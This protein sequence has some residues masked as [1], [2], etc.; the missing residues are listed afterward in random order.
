MTSLGFRND[1]RASSNEPQLLLVIK[2]EQFWA[3]DKFCVPKM[4][5]SPNQRT[6]LVICPIFLDFESNLTGDQLLTD[7]CDISL[8][9]T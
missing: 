6:V 7:K 1:D 3:N 2:D 9:A 4:V 5:V 8:E